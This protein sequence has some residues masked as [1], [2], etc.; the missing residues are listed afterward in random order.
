M[1]NLKKTIRQT[2]LAVL[3]V[4]LILVAVSCSK[5]S[6]SGTSASASGTSAAVAT[7]TAPAASEDLLARIKAK[8]EITI[9]MEG[10]WAPWTYHDETDKLVGYDTEIGQA[11]ADYLGVKANFI[12]GEWDGLLAGLESGRYDIM[13]NGVDVTPQREEKF[14]FSEPYAYI[15]TALVVRGDNDT[16]KGF[17]D[18]KGKVTAN[19]IGSTY[20]E[21]AEQYGATVSGVDT[22]GQTIEVLLAG[23]VDATLNAD[24]SFYDYLK[25]QPD[26][27]IK[28]V[29]FA[30]DINKVAIPMKKGSDSETLLDAVNEALANIR[31]DGTLTALSEKYFGSD[32]SNLD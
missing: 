29:A 21:L 17:E 12:E 14:F 15:R 26:T 19:S 4:A 24:V 30:D 16:I 6:A 32:V 28:M 11:I 8:G 25:A 5:S 1:K 22:L 10:N 20:M 13:I 9:A 27:N 23:R 7:T 3:S 18:L 31:A 2:A